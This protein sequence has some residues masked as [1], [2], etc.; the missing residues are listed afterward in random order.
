MFEVDDSV[1]VSGKVLKSDGQGGGTTLNLTN[2][3][4]TVKKLCDEHVYVETQHGVHYFHE[5]Q[6]T[7]V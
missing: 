7:A 1:T 3:A 4:G 6:V 5:S 2:E